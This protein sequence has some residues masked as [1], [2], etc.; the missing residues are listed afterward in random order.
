MTHESI[1]EKY[2]QVVTIN[3]EGGNLECFDKDGNKLN[4]DLD[5][6]PSKSNAEIKLE[7]DREK[8]ILLTTLIITLPNGLR[9]YADPQSRTDISSTIIEAQNQNATDEMTTQWKTPDGIKA[10][11]LK[12]LKDANALALN[13]K[14]KIIGVN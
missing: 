3:G 2:Q 11:T 12:D 4:L 9:F 13:E 14:A 6:V 1:R 5:V 10:V 8:E 7:Q